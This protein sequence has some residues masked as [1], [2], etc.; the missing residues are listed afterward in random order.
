MERTHLRALQD[1][2][3]RLVISSHSP[4]CRGAQEKDAQCQ[5]PRHSGVTMVL[6]LLEE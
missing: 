6:T 2:L 3:G 5:E 1:T 4:H